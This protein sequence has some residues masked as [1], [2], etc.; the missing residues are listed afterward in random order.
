MADLNRR[1]NDL[2]R[3]LSRIGDT[4][5]PVCRGY[6]P[7]SVVIARPLVEGDRKPCAACGRE[8]TIIQVMCPG[9]EASGGVTT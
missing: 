8:G 1:L 5:C 7:P 2:E 3:V 4:S 9:L 6:P